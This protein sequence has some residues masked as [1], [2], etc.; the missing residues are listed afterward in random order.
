MCPLCLRP[1]L[2][3]SCPN[4]HEWEGRSAGSIRRAVPTGTEADGEEQYGGGGIDKQT[5]NNNRQEIKKREGR[6]IEERIGQ[7]RQVPLPEDRY[8]HLYGE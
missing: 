3:L 2:P 6:Q 1:V 4:G 8:R 7:T 5:H